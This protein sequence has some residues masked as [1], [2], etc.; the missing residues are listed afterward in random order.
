MMFLIRKLKRCSG[1]ECGV[2][3]HRTNAKRRENAMKMLGPEIIAHQNTHTVVGLLSRYIAA[4]IGNSVAGQ[5]AR[6]Q[7]SPI[8]MPLPLMS[9]LASC[10]LAV[11]LPLIPSGRNFYRGCTN[12]LRLQRVLDEYG[13]TLQSPVPLELFLLDEHGS[14]LVSKFHRTLTSTPSPRINT[15]MQEI[16]STGV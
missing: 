14:P 13:A 12:K 15:I 4:C 5:Q 3:T 2:G 6:R 16:Q 9:H 10:L 7:A 8:Q 1:W 11:N